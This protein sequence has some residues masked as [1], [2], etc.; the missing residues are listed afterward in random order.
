MGDEM[1]GCA[2]LDCAF[3]R[4]RDVQTDAC[5]VFA[6]YPLHAGAGVREGEV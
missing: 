6:Y 5:R 4:E 3:L 2:R 1:I